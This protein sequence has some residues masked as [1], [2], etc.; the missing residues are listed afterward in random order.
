MRIKGLK[1]AIALLII[2]AFAV[3][4]I[5]FYSLPHASAL[6]TFEKR[7][8]LE[9]SESDFK[10]NHGGAY[11]TIHYAGANLRPWE[12]VSVTTPGNPALPVRI[13]Q[14][15]LPPDARVLEVAAETASSRVLDGQFRVEPARQP[16][17]LGN[18]SVSVENPNV[19]KKDALFPASVSKQLYSGKMRGFVI[20]TAAV[21]PLQ[22]NPLKGKITLH[23]KITLTVKYDRGGTSKPYSSETFKLFET[24]VSDLVSNPGDIPS[25]LP[26]VSTGEAARA[27]PQD[28]TLLIITSS[29]LSSRFQTLA[30][31]RTAEGLAAEIVTDWSSYSGS[32]S[33]AKIKNLITYYV[34]NRGT[35]F[36]L[37]GGDDSVIPDRDCYCAVNTTVDDTIPADFYYACLDDS[38][39]S[40]GNG[41]YGESGDS[42]DYLPDV[43]VG[44]VP[45]RTSSQAT[46]FVN[47]LLAYEKNPPT[48][49]FAEKL[50]AGGCEFWETYSGSAVVAEYGHSPVSDAEAKFTRIYLGYIAPHWSGN[51]YRLF[52]T[53]TEFD[54]S[55]PGDYDVTASHMRSKISQGY[56]HVFFGTHGNIE[57]WSTEDSYGFWDYD[58][59]VV[60]NNGRFSLIYTIAC[61][62]AH[63]DGSIDPCLGEAF[64]RNTSGGAVAYMGASRYNWGEYGP[65]ITDDPAHMFAATYFENLFNTSQKTVG[66]VFS[67]HKAAFAGSAHSEPVMRWLL[68][69]LTILGDPS[70]PVYTYNPS[71]FAPAVPANASI[72]G[73]QFNVITGVAGAGVCLSKGADFYVTGTADSSGNFSATLPAMTSGMVRVVLT[74]KN[75]KPYDVYVPVVEPSGPPAVTNPTPSD[76]LTGVNS[77]ITLAWD[78]SNG[79]STYRVQLGTFGQSGNPP[80]IANVSSCSCPLSLAFETSYVWRVDAVGPTG[81]VTAGPLWHFMTEIYPY[82]PGKANATS[83]SNGAE[84]VDAAAVQLSWTRPTGATSFD[85]YFGET[86]PPEFRANVPSTSWTPGTV[87]YFTRYY[88]RV[89]ARNSIGVAEGDVVEFMTAEEPG[90]DWDPWD[91]LPVNGTLL[92]PLLNPQLHGPHTLCGADVLDNFK[93]YMKEGK[94]YKFE[95]IYASGDATAE[96]YS[97]PNKYVLLASDTGLPFSLTHLCLKSQTYYLGIKRPYSSDNSS[98]TLK[99]YE[100]M[101]STAPDAVISGLP[102]VGSTG[103]STAVGLLEWPASSKAESYAVYFGTHYP[104]AYLGNTASVY[105]VL[106][107]LQFDATYFW[108]IDAK[109]RYSSTTGAPFYFLTEPYNAADTYDPADDLPANCSIIVPSSLPQSHGPH[110]FNS[111]DWNDWFR[112]QATTGITYIFYC[113]N[114]DGDAK[115]FLYSDGNCSLLASQDDDSGGGVNFRISYVAPKSGWMYLCVK[116]FYKPSDFSYVLWFESANAVS[117]PGAV[118]YGYPY[119]GETDVPIDTYL[120][121]APAENAASYSLFFGTSD[122]P[123]PVALGLA[124]SVY[125]IPY[126]LEPGTTYYWRVDAVN[127]FGNSQGSVWSFATE[128]L[129]CRD[130]WDPLDDTPFG[131]T[132]ISTVSAPVSHGPHTITTLDNADCFKVHLVSGCTYRIDSIGGIGD[133]QIMVYSDSTLENALAGDDDGYMTQFY[134]NFTAVQSGYYFMVVSP[135]Y[136]GAEASYKLNIRPLSN[137]SGAC[138]DA[139]G[140]TA[141]PG[142]GKVILE[143]QP[144]PTPNVQGYKLYINAG[145]G[146]GGAVDL[147]NVASYTAKGL[148]GNRLY[149]FKLTAYNQMNNESPGV[150]AEA[151]PRSAPGG[152]CQMGGDDAE[153]GI[154]LIIISAVLLLF[155]TLKTLRNRQ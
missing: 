152:G 58:A 39:D 85:V 138:K 38:W 34:D 126:L 83:P 136:F 90:D 124:N 6:D 64:I 25:C 42:C 37:L 61:L 88:W 45:V 5:L 151:M 144:S 123:S 125:I 8:T 101:E 97:D 76:G 27:G 93:V 51:L 75:Y 31:W 135:G 24:T 71:T 111:C 84:D 154:S 21:S 62:T 68:Y 115:A 70:M 96:L 110:A 36:V 120:S 72:F 153:N 146:F 116:P 77:S 16:V 43:I 2:I 11:T 100:S 81:A 13:V 52:D 74:A 17:P 7:F 9:F 82:P 3:I 53:I 66:G 46:S 133:P 80:N 108:R 32:D 119:D 130:A 105:Y 137:V 23:E 55:V 18:S 140:L 4:Q 134:L 20:A 114:S 40:N 128:S 150:T 155:W 33:Q 59:D 104:P 14:L 145:A 103:V 92:E 47:K 139:S 129:D 148:K 122:P 78:P 57:A 54:S 87:K 131:A 12:T 44:R 143:W 67:A 112:F 73:G 60:G 142:A 30:D 19:Y 22:Y 26:P 91:N 141:T 29:T 121:W 79:A 99:Y 113:D 1:F 56:N 89:D 147:G 95:A 15:V 65:Q 106:G 49:D 117:M 132:E 149:S 127:M 86:N 94:V 28:A 35:Q 48:A 69:A 98:Y 50:L 102:V 107:D 118:Q 63:F 109:N 41:V 10:F